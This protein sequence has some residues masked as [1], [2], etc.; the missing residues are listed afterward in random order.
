MQI[1]KFSILVILICWLC[2]FLLEVKAQAY[3]T[4]EMVE[5][6]TECHICLKSISEYVEKETSDWGYNISS[7]YPTY[8]HMWG[9]PDS[10]HTQTILTNKAIEVCPRCLNK[11][12]AKLQREMDRYWD[13][14]VDT[15]I[16]EE[17]HLR[18][19]YTTKREEDKI[20]ELQRKIDGLLKERE[21]LM[22]KK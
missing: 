7:T 17:K 14:W 11:Y 21:K 10:L 12:G 18:E 13:R 6:K 4:P 9:I 5:V 19:H 3:I 2:F 1:L 16:E 15:F 8:G 22:D 20:I